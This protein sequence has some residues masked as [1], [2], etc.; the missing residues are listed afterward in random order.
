MRDCYKFLEDV[1]ELKWFYSYVLP[2]LKPH[3]CYFMSNSARN[4]KLDESERELYQVGRSEM[5]KKEVVTDDSFERLLK[6][7]RRLETNRYAYL[8]KSGLPYPDK[9]LVLYM[10]IVP[11]DAYRAMREQMRNL[12]EIQGELTDSLV[13]GSGQ[14][15][16]SAWQ[17]I[18]KSH[19]TGQSVFARSFSEKVWIDVDMDCKGWSGNLAGW[20]AV[21]G[22]KQFLMKELGLGNYVQVWTA[23]G[24]HWILRSSSLRE[25]GRRNNRDPITVVCDEMKNIMGREGIYDPEIDEVIR[26]KN[27]MIPLPGTLQYGDHLVTVV[28]KE[29]FRP[30][31]MT[32][33]WPEH[34]E[35][36]YDWPEVTARLGA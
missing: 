6:G 2:P 36:I 33:P 32:H 21:D 28:N 16:E 11:T 30:E 23:G 25:V 35:R 14:G 31:Q 17:N 19:T 27:E 8:T 20:T 3:E 9:V 12:M 34:V 18:R 29:D 13:K 4:K 15:V 22:I 10:N 24:W 26:N 7:V 1:N 5:W